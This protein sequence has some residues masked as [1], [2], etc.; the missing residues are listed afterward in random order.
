MIKVQEQSSKGPKIMTA[1]W[2]KGQR[3][4]GRGNG[5]IENQCPFTLE[6]VLHYASAVHVKSTEENVSPPTTQV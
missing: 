6:Q 1:Q 5:Q 4:S 3:G 2:S